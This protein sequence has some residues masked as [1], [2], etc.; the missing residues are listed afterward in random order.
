MRF[1]KQIRPVAQRAHIERIGTKLFLSQHFHGQVG[2]ILVLQLDGADVVF[3]RFLV[4]DNLRHTIRANND[5]HFC[6]VA[7]LHGH[8]LGQ[9]VLLFKEH[10]KFALY[11]GQCEHTIMQRGQNRDQ[12]IGVM[13]D[14]V[15][16]KVVFI[17]VVG[18][19]VGVEIPLQFLFQLGVG[20]LCTQHIL[21]LGKVRGCRHA[22]SSGA[23]H[24]GAGL[25]TR[26]Q[27]QSQQTEHRHDQNGFPVPGR[28][29]GYPFAALGRQLYYPETVLCGGGCTLCGGLSGLPCSFGVL[30]LDTLFLPHPGNGIAGGLRD[31]RI[32][33]QRFLVKVFCIGRHELTLCLFHGLVG[34]HL[35]VPDAAA[36]D[37]GGLMLHQ[38]FTLV[39]T[40]HTHIFVF[41]LVD[42]SVSEQQRFR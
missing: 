27:E 14:F 7:Y 40:L 1:A 9:D 35:V 8:G 5:H 29:F 18:G 41:D 12:H 37:L 42:F 13:L 34:L 30:L 32:V 22:G 10:F 17:V 6:T 38:F 21:V 4:G 26:Y 11:L 19:L 36:D 3:I 2:Q 24:H 16:I 31:L 28:K 33:P 39:A 25:Q 23:R 20:F 15:Q